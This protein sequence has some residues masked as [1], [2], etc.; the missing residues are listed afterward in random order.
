MRQYG[1]RKEIAPMN[2]MTVFKKFPDQESC[3]AHLE[4]ARWGTILSVYTVKAMML[5]AS[6]KTR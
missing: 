1:G 5:L 4:K 6:V 2:L 3:I